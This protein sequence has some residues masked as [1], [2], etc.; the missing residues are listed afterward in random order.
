M[1]STSSQYSI[2]PCGEQGSVLVIALVMLL[3]LTMMA[4]VGVQSTS[5]Q[6]RMAGN[7]RDK[8]I[9]FQAAE[10]A[11]RDAELAL[12]NDFS[13]LTGESCFYDHTDSSPRSDLCDHLLGDAFP[14]MPRFFVEELAPQPESLDPSDP[15]PDPSLYLITSRSAGGMTDTVT[16]LQSMYKR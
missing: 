11:L 14:N 15:L 3:V 13:A 1:K 12:R 2:T 4:V 9:S 7:M 5:I 16:I 10:A 6:E 8:D